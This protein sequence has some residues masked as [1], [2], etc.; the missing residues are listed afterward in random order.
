LLL[1]QQ[2]LYGT[3]HIIAVFP[4]FVFNKPRNP[5]MIWMGIKFIKLNIASLLSFDNANSWKYNL[6]TKHQILFMPQFGY[7]ANPSKKLISEIKK[8]RKLGADYVEIPF[9]TGNHPSIIVRDRKKI[10][11]ALEK[12]D[13]FCTIHMAYWADLGS[14]YIAV[15]EGWRNECMLALNAAHHIGARK[16]LVHARPVGGFSMRSKRFKKETIKNLSFNLMQLKNQAKDMGIAFVTE[17]EPFDERITL[18]DF[19]SISKKSEAHVALDI[20]HAYIDS[21]NKELK[22][23][24]RKLGKRIR[25][26]HFSDNHGEGDEHLP[27]GQG[28]INYE[29]VVRELKRAG[30][31]DTISFEI[32]NG[33]ERGIKSS[34]NKIKKLWEE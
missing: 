10:S 31:D 8:A 34:I 21:S 23:V 1:I 13:M 5:H 28:S 3:I 25:H 6:L 29:M 18:K 19:I 20:G 17:N 2:K 24:I 22:N 27:I 12:K 7:M 15:R 32:F 30:Y 14:E 9:E 11:K 16:F 26:V 4:P 33:G